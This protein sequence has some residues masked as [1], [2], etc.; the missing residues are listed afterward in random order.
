MV[1]AVLTTGEVTRLLDER[2]AA[3]RLLSIAC[4]N[5]TLILALA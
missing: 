1:D 5:F 4:S 3:G 2:G